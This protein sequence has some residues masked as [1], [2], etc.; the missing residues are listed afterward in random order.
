MKLDQARLMT[1]HAAQLADAGQA[2]RD[3]GG[4]AK[5]AG[6]EAAWFATWAASMTLGGYS[7]SREYPVERWLRAP[8]SRSC[9]RARPTSSA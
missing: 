9:T 1:Y 3:R 7:Y 2:V 8:S 5:L 6:S 4:E